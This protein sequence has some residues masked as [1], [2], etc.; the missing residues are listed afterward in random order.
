VADA[1]RGWPTFV[2]VGV[3]LAVGVSIAVATIAFTA[4]RY[5]ESVVEVR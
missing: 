1:P 4:Q 3:A 5:F 2:A